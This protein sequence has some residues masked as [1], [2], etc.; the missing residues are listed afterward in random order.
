MTVFGGE[1]NAV[2]GDRC[3]VKGVFPVKA[4]KDKEE[5]E[6]NGGEEKICG[7]FCSLVYFTFERYCENV[8]EKSLLNLTEYK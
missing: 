5:E 2:G 3:A 7:H 8:H 4:A 6:G 1:A